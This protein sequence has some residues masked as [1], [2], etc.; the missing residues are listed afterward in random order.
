M[1]Q[2]ATLTRCSKLILQDTASKFILPQEENSD[3]NLFHTHCSFKQVEHRSF[4]GGESIDSITGLV[5]NPPRLLV[6]PS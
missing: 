3:K 5:P 6:G 4:H 1:L 2:D